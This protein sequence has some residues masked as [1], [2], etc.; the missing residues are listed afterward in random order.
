MAALRSIGEHKAFFKQLMDMLEQ[1][2]G[3][4]SEIVLHDLTLDYNHTIVDI[5]NGHITGRGIGDCGSNLGLEVLRGNVVE[6]ERYNYITHTPDGKLLRS[7]SMYMKDDEGKV[8]G[9]LCINTD[10]TESLKFEK[11][12]HDFNN[13]PQ[14][15]ASETREVFATDVKELLEHLLEEG[16]KRVGK[17]AADMNKAERESFIEYLDQNGAFLITKSSERVCE[18]LGVSRFTLYSALDKLR[19]GAPEAQ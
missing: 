18:F 14:G 8:I 3:R 19:N 13:Y 4:G 7:S 5:R 2:F 11:F 17:C 16:E 9:S 6:G 12:L 1:Q 10:I 15:A